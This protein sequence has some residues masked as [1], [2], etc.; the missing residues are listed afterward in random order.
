MLNDLATFWNAALD[1][2]SAPWVMVLVLALTTLLLEDVAIAAGAALAAMGSLSWPMAFLGVAGG[3]AFGDLLL[4]A[5]GAW[6]QRW[7]LLQRRSVGERAQHMRQRL[8]GDLPSAV[9]LARVIP[10]LRLITYTACGLLR[11]PL[12][13]FTAWVLL[14]VSLWTVGLFWF[15]AWLGQWIAQAL[16]WPVAVAVAAPIVLL[17]LLTALAKRLWRT[18]PQASAAPEAG[19]RPPRTQTGPQAALPSALPSALPPHPAPRGPGHP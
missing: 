5:T 2:T 9:L 13:R 14:A 12:L 17:A 15:S 11:V 4:Y 10:G 7:P 3:I 18:A 1:G 8:L 16:G 19:P 6:G